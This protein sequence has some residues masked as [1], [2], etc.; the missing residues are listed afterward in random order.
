MSTLTR[1]PPPVERP[2]PPPPT[3]PAV[4]P[5]PLEKP[6]R[7]T[8][9]DAYRGFIMLAM[10]SSSGFGLAEVAKHFP[11][12]PVWE[13]VGYHTDHVAWVGCGF[14]DLIQ[15]AFMFMAGVAIPY[16]YASRKAKGE[17]DA[18]ILFH[19]AIRSALL[20][21]LG[22][23]LSST[24]QGEPGHI[25]VNVLSQIGLGYFFVYLLRGRGLIVELAATAV[26]LFGY[27]LLF[28]LWPL[29]PAGFDYSTVGLDNTWQH[30]TGFFAHWEKNTN[31]AAAIDVWLLNLL[32]AY[33][34][35]AFAFNP[36]GYQTLNFVPSMATMIF[37]L[38]AGELLRGPK[39][40]AAKLGWLVV[41]GAACLVLGLVAGVTVCPIVKRIWTPS[42]AVY[43]A[44]W[45]LWMLAAFYAVCDLKG[46]KSW[47]FPLT[48]V[49]MNS[50]AIYLM[51]QLLRGPIK[52]TFRN[53]VGEWWI[54]QRTGPL[55]LPTVQD[56]VILVV[57]W[58][59]CL[60]LYRRKLFLRI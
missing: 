30:M 25:L 14:W 38:M 7:L 21:L 23:F 15:P 31:A 56:A 52:G 53:L 6:A 32:P 49:G 33:H 50:I 8:S 55:W 34:A 46:W 11:G 3:T 57:L 18:K 45:V 22:I 4:L 17:S 26:I 42:F 48:V 43:S 24:S 12:N 35:K 29:P 47:A 59:A 54:T 37:G 39:T 19:V 16:S 44:G 41:A 36:G 13:V 40:A 58:L 20:V 27:W 2:T 5:R 60:W 10:A 1:T 28:V 9:L 51:S